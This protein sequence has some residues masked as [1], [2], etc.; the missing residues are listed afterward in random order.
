MS[1][2]PYVVDDYGFKFFEM[3]KTIVGDYD[4]NH[5]KKNKSYSLILALTLNLKQ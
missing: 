5:L 2:K 1:P 4:F 3:V